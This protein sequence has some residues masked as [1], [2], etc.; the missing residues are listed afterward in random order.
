MTTEALGA[1]EQDLRR[2]VAEGRYEDVERLVG[3]YCNS[4]FAH[5]ATLDPVDSRIPEVGS[6]VREVLSW[7]NLML[8]TARSTIAAPLASLPLVSRYLDSPHTP[9]RTRL[10]A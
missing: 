1:A 5:L 7:A 4:A 9:H 2:A 6:H 8:L 10:E 3:S